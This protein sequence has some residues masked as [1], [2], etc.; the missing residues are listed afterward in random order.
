[1]SRNVRQIGYLG[2]FILVLLRVAIGWQF[3]YEGLW[4]LGTQ[5]TA[6]PWTAE[7]YLVNARGPFREKFRGMVDDPNGFDKL[8]YDKVVARWD[9]WRDRFGGGSRQSLCQAAGLAQE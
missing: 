8:D 3:L 1:M 4:K 6:R 9:D 2:C 5:K 7:G